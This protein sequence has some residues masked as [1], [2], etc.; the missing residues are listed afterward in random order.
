MRVK[1]DMFW[2]GILLESGESAFGAAEVH[3][4]LPH[5]LPWSVNTTVQ[6]SVKPTAWFLSDLLWAWRKASSLWEYLKVRP[7]LEGF[8]S[9]VQAVKYTYPS[10]MAV[11]PIPVSLSDTL[12]SH[13]TSLWRYPS[14]FSAPNHNLPLLSGPGVAE[15]SCP[16][17]ERPQAA[18]CR[19]T[20]ALQ[21]ISL[22]ATLPV[23]PIEPWLHS[24]CKIMRK[25]TSHVSKFC[26][27]VQE[28]WLTIRDNVVNFLQNVF[29]MAILGKN[30]FMFVLIKLTI[31]RRNSE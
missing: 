14:T 13:L 2:R 9:K 1:P 20:C 4:C 22:E 12:P 15:T 28:M 5:Q 26:F 27:N 30:F 11:M 10:V 21:T 18:T 23:T 24:L 29:V 25:C 8:D 17:Q 16:N 19:V 6:D 7:Q 3:F 31:C